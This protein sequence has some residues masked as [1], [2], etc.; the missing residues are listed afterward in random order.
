MQK[1]TTEELKTRIEA[2]EAEGNDSPDA[3]AQLAFF[4]ELHAYG[5]RR[6][7]MT[8]SEVLVPADMAGVRKLHDSLV[9]L[10][11]DLDNSDVTHTHAKHLKRDIEELRRIMREPK[12][13]K[14]YTRETA[15]KSRVVVKD[16]VV[17]GWFEHDGIKFW[18]PSEIIEVDAQL[19]VYAT[20]EDDL[21]DINLDLND[22]EQH[23]NAGNFLVILKKVTPSGNCLNASARSA[24]TAA[25]FSL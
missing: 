1:L 19:G 12:R 3:K 10:H 4:K 17:R 21:G 11:R 6:E 15:S 23:R 8:N 7:A 18:K 9:R 20:G 2:L 16:G 13:L 5:Q 25:S 22:V 24:S 14:R